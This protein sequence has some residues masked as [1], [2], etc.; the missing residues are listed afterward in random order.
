MLQIFR[1]LDPKM[2]K[3]YESI[4]RTIPTQHADLGEG[5]Y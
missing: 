1:T 3:Q 4:Y 5:I 2:T